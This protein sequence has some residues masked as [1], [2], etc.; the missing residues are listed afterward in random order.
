MIDIQLIIAP[1]IGIVLLLYLVI[2]VKLNAFISLLIASVCTGLAAGM[3]P[4]TVIDSIQQGMGGT[5]GFVATV[6]G[7]GAIFG[8]ILEHSGGAEAV[9][10]KMLKGFGRQNASWAMMI[11]G[12]FVAIPVFFDVAFIILVPLIYALGRDT[13]KSLLYYGIPLL[14]GLAVTHTFIPPT[15]G[16]IAVADII[17]ADLGWVIFFGFIVG[18]PTAVVAGPL[19]GNYIGKKID[20]R[21]P[22]Y[23]KQELSEESD[24]D[25]LPPF[26]LLLAIISVPLL[27]ILA[28]T[29]T[30]TLVDQGTVQSSILTD[31]VMFIGHPF[32]AL[33]IAVLIALY[34]L[35]IKRGTAKEQLSK[36]TMES[37]KPAGII[38]LITG[39][40]GVFKQVLID[41][42][43][44]DM[45]AATMQDLGLPVMLLAWLIAAAVRLTQGSATVA[46]ITAAG[47]VSPILSGFAYGEPFKALLVLAIAAGATTFSHVNDSGFWLVNRYF[48]M[49]EKETLKSW[50]VMTAIISVSGLLLCLLIAL[51]L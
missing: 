13:G 8:Q 15:P 37:M 34:W 36:I 16:P 33:T 42:G 20:V 40:G 51:F 18:F 38:I 43:V 5:L 39:A 50:S 2:R 48:G 12:F 21:V 49:S 41:S 6:V 17:G 28:N 3:P 19:F 46:M 7:L 26:S 29:L 1:L 11:T 22:D 24:S 47:I 27:L 9:A 25:S 10:R 44:G 32:I 23:I 14:T 31:L 45:L 4:S 30:Q 35:G